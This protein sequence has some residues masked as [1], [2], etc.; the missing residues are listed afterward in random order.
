MKKEQLQMVASWVVLIAMIFYVVIADA[1]SMIAPFLFF[2]ASYIIR[3]GIPDM[4]HMQF[5]EMRKIL[6]Y[7]AAIHYLA[8]AIFGLYIAFYKPEL[9]TYNTTQSILFFIALFLPLL[10]GVIET[11]TKLFNS[12]GN[13]NA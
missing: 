11:E 13:K 6:Q 4:G 2:M 3:I 5:H 10:P 8:F 7:Y 12:Y 9:M 1:P